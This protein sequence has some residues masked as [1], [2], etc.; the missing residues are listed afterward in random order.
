MQCFTAVPMSE[1]MYY[2]CIVSV[3]YFVYGY[4]RTILCVWVYTVN[5][6]NFSALRSLG[7]ADYKPQ[8]WMLAQCLDARKSG[9][10]HIT[11][12]SLIY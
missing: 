5:G 6:C 12:N 9:F 11:T 7:R 2:E 8:L 3:P 1:D 4:I 10:S